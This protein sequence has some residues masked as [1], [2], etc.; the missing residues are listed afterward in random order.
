M[1]LMIIRTTK[2]YDQVPALRA[3]AFAT[4]DPN[5][6]IQKMFQHL[7]SLFLENSPHIYKS[8]RMCTCTPML[9]RFLLKGLQILKY[10]SSATATTV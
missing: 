4:L 9:T 7:L 8:V 6:Q 1:Q 3:T 5:F 2:H 10:R